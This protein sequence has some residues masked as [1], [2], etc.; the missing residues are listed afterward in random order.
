MGLVL[1]ST[2]PYRKVLL[3]RLGLPFSQ[4]S[5]KCDEDAFK[6][7]RS[8]G[9][10][11]LARLLATEKVNSLISQYSL[12][13]I[14]GGDQVVDLDGMI[15]G[16]PTTIEAAIDQLIE[17]SGRSHRLATA[18]A[19]WDE[20]RLNTHVDITTLTM[21]TLELSAI[22]RYV[23]ADQ[24]LD[25]AGSYKLE[26]RGISLFERIETADYTAIIGLP[27]MALTSMLRGVGYVI[28]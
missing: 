6:A 8:L 5:P 10:A 3:D 25:C 23:E 12:D 1:A 13:T 9:A 4:A 17:L 7:Q 11:G 22:R 24:P 14:I 27:L 16:K 28:P 20:G 2:S 18:V 21:R 19:V 26:S 15:L